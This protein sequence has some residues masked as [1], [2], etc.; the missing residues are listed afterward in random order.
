M[1]AIKPRSNPPRIYSNEL[2][3]GKRNGSRSSKNQLLVRRTNIH[4]DIQN[5]YPKIEVPW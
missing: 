4:R 1:Q 5:C 2:D 3:E